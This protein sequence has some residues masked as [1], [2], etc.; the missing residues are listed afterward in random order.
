MLGLIPP[1]AREVRLDGRSIAGRRHAEIAYVDQAQSS[2][3]AY[4]MPDIVLMGRIAI[5]GHLLGRA[6]PRRKHWP[7]S[8]S[9]A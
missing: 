5:S 3:F 2:Q 4:T 9:S 1:Q 6:G 8:P 7:A